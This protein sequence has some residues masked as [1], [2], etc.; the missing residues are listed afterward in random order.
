MTTLRALVGAG[1]LG[2]VIGFVVFVP[3]GWA[4]VLYTAENASVE[5]SKPLPGIRGTSIEEIIKSRP[6]QRKA[7]LVQKEI[8]PRA[9]YEKIV[10]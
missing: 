6:D 4:L 5:H 9:A 7:E 2:A 1:F 3:L 8:L 10:Y